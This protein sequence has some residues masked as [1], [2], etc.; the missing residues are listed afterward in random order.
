MSGHCKGVCTS[1]LRVRCY[2]RWPWWTPGTAD[3]SGAV[4]KMCGTLR[5][6][7]GRYARDRWRF[8]RT[9]QGCAR[10]ARTYFLLIFQWAEGIVKTCN[11]LGMCQQ[12]PLMPERGSATSESRERFSAFRPSVCCFEETF[13]GSARPGGHPRAACACYRGV[14]FPLCCDK[15]L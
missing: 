2:A 4:R 10:P 7:V 5:Q 9:L 6:N 15:R 11:Q 3:E 8:S 12:F 14:A 13:A 1:G